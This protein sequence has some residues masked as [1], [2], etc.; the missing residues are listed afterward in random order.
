MYEAKELDTQDKLAYMNSLIKTPVSIVGEYANKYHLVPQYD[1]IYN[2]YLSSKVRFEYSL[3]MGKYATVGVGSSK[4][5]AKQEAALNLLGIM[6]DE[7]PELLDTDFKIFDSDKYTVSQFDNNV[8]VNA[9]G[10]LNEICKKYQLELPEFNL[11]REEGQCHAKLFTVSCRVAKIIEISSNKTKKQAKQLAAFQMINKLMSIDK[12]FIMEEKQNVS[13][14]MKVL[15]RVEMIKS[16][17]IKKS[18]S[19]NKNIVNYHLLFKKTE[20]INSD[21]LNN[22][23]NHYNKY[24]ELDLLKP[25]KLLCRIVNECGMYLIAKTINTELLDKNYN[26]IYMLS[27]D[28][29]IYPPVYGLGM[30]DNIENAQQIAAK[31]LLIAFCILLK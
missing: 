14:A 31:E 7:K 24:N 19:M 26:C 20:R 10:K 6:I 11:I 28:N 16:E 3:T 9:I 15:E 1:L 21:L 22:V 4:K 23:V 29:D 5:E 30:A 18:A 8:K 17:Q 27:V 25:F 13:D 12:S 2:G